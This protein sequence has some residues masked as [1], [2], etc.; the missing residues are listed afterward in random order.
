MGSATLRQPPPF[1]MRWVCMHRCPHC[2]SPHPSPP[3]P[4]Q[5][6]MERPIE[7]GEV[8]LDALLRVVLGADHT[9]RVEGVLALATAAM[10]RAGEHTDSFADLR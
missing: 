3:P 8:D 4:S 5:D 1:E 10:Q 7:G 6:Y 9:E 2:A